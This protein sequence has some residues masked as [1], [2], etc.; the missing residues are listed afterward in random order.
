MACYYRWIAMVVVEDDFLSDIDVI[1]YGFKPPTKTVSNFTLYQGFIPALVSALDQ[2]YKRVV[3]ELASVD[4]NMSMILYNGKP[5]LCI[6]KIL[7]SKN[8]PSILSNN[9]IFNVKKVLEY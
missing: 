5:Y 3:N 9:S 7:K 6:F 4:I 8:P 2:E 1:N